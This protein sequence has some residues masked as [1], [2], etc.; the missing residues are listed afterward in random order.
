MPETTT[1]DSFLDCLRKSGLLEKFQLEAYLADLRNSAAPLTTSADLAARLERD[2]MLTNF[3]SRYLLQGHYKGLILAGK[4]KVLDLLGAGGIGRVYLCEHMTMHRHVAVKILPTAS[5]EI[6]GVVERFYR[7]ARAVASFDDEYILRVFDVDR[8]G[9]LHFMVMEYIEGMTLQEIVAREGPLEPGR[10]CWYIR[11]AALGLQHAHEA[12]WVHRDI[13]P[14]NLLADR[15][16]HLKILDLGLARFFLSE[17]DNLTTQVNERAIMGTADYIAPEQAVSVHEV[18]GRADLYSL[19]VTLYFLLVG[20]PP[21]HDGTINQKLIW[22]Q[23]RQPPPLLQLRPGLPPE[24]VRVVDKM[25]AKKPGERYQSGNEV[26]TALAPWTVPPSGEMALPAGRMVSRSEP[27]SGSKIKMQQSQMS[28]TGAVSQP[29]TPLDN[30]ATMHPTPA[31]VTR[32]PSAPPVRESVTTRTAER[33]TV[34]RDTPPSEEALAGAETI[35]P[36]ARAGKVAPKAVA[37]PWKPRGPAWW[38]LVVG[39]P[40][41]GLLAVVLLVR[42]FGMG[43]GPKTTE[44]SGKRSPE[45]VARRVLISSGRRTLVVTK[46]PILSRL[47]GNRHRATLRQAL[48]QAESGDVIRVI[49][50]DL[51]DRN[52]FGKIGFFRDRIALTEKF[53]KN[54]SL[55]GFDA[56]GNPGLVLWEPPEDDGNTTPLLSVANVAN[57]SVRG[58]EFKSEARIDSLVAVSGYCPGLRLE[59]CQINVG[60]MNGLVAEYARGHRNDRIVFQRLRFAAPLLLKAA[61]AIVLQAKNDK[62]CQE[63]LISDCRFEGPCEVGLRLQGPMAYLD[64]RLNRFFNLDSGILVAEGAPKSGLQLTVAN[65]TFCQVDTVFR[66]KQLPAAGGEEGIHLSNNLFAQ[67]TSAL[68]RQDGLKVDA[69]AVKDLFPT[70]KGN[71]REPG[72]CQEGVFF[73]EVKPLAFQ[74]VPTD[75]ADERFL[76]PPADSPLRKAGFEGSPVGVVEETSHPRWHIAG[77][78]A[79]VRPSIQIQAGGSTFVAPAMKKWIEVFG[80]DV[81]AQIDYQGVGSGKGIE[82][83]ISREFD[84]GCSDVPLTDAQIKKAESVGGEVL[85]I[86]L[87]LGAVVPIYNLPGVEAPLKFSGPVLA[88]IYLGKIKMW[89]HPDLARINPDIVLPDQPITPVH[90][91]DGSGTTGIWTDYLN[92]VSPDWKGVGT[93]T[94]VKWPTEVEAKGS[95]GMV[96]KVRNTRGALGY[97]EMTY[98]LESKLRYGSVKNRAGK[99]ILADDTSVQLAVQ[100]VVKELPDDLRYSLTDT[101]GDRAYPLAGTSWALLYR[102]QPAEKGKATVE[103]LRKATTTHKGQ[104]L[105][106]DLH[107]GQIPVELQAH[108]KTKLGLVSFR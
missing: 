68:A 39:L 84:F 43:P 27:G 40:L 9:R 13:K 57:L 46:D 90:R 102:D 30:Q 42:F 81:S 103:F 64:I 108:I 2:G 66:F 52:A 29:D 45:E 11:Q 105:S 53:P 25:L 26:F 38:G 55:E 74:P 94:T 35:A 5:A 34:P 37:T 76:L 71:I 92:K 95:E 23:V 87:V 88:D 48:E 77:A 96:A 89:N 101:P 10:A 106:F 1:L 80:R 82:K 49:A 50:D 20:H 54:V 44:P 78:P 73:N 69:M 67:G 6:P 18:D 51:G 72:S 79:R 17:Q 56:D 70:L 4:Y 85:H 28:M 33:P 41:L 97:V 58:F 19:G 21:F 59:D 63:M 24:L 16:H 14:A 7:E 75:P 62:P 60:S 61:A 93:G 98:A 104:L 12:G 99:F 91:S 22:H 15:R 3:Q 100:S 65:N 83:F 47:L 8:S 31:L 36:S 86:P 107:Y 32:A